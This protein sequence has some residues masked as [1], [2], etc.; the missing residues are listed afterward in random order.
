MFAV[1]FHSNVHFLHIISKLLIWLFSGFL[2]VTFSIDMGFKTLHTHFTRSLN[3]TIKQ[4]GQADL[5]EVGQKQILKELLKVVF[6]REISNDT[7]R[8][9]RKKSD[10]LRRSRSRSRR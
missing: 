2:H 6:D 1:V 7:Q 5:R 3:P 9:H 8:R 4:F 10:G